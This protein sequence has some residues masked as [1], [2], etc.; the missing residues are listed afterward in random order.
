MQKPLKDYLALTPAQVDMDDPDIPE[1][2]KIRARNALQR[3]A[4]EKARAARADRQETSR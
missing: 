4:Q 1:S 2:I 3:E